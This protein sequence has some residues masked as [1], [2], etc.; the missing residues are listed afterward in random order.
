MVYVDTSVVVA[1]LTV[2]PSTQ[3]VTAW[4]SGLKQLPVSSD[5]LLTEFSSAISIKVRTGR[6]AQADAK[7]VRRE[8]KLLSENGLRLAPV[9]RA[10]FGLAAEMAQAHRYGLRSG[11]SLHLAIARETGAKTIATL[12]GTMARNARRFKMVTVNF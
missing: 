5:W 1:L 11:D 7:V 4:F 9:S 3:A 2:E 10:A 12:D 6:L 8:F